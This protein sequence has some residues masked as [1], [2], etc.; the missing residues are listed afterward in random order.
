MAN[1]YTRIKDIITDNGLFPN[2]ALYSLLMGAVL[3]TI[4]LDYAFGSITCG[5][6]LLVVFWAQR[7]VKITVNKALI[8]PMLFYLLML[9]SLFWTK[10]FKAT[11]S[12]LQKEILFL[13]MPV[14]FLLLQDVG[15]NVM[16]GSFRIYSYCMLA[17][18]H[19]YV[20]KAAIQY[21]AS[22]DKTVFFYHGLVSLDSNAIYV[23]VFASFALWYFVYYNNKSI[24][25]R[26]AVFFLAVFI[27]LLSSKSI[28]F[29]NL[30][31]TAIYFIGFSGIPRKVKFL[32]IG[33]ISL[34]MVFSFVFVSQIR[35][36]FLIEYETA[37]TDDTINKEN[38]TITNV[39]LYQAWNTEQFHPNNYFPGTALRIYQIR[40]FKEM[41]S[42]DPILFT[43][44]G[45]EASQHK[46][47]QKRAEHNLHEGYGDFNFHN[48]YVQTFA[49]LGIFGLLLLISMLGFTFRNAWLHKDFL[50]L[51]FA[52]TMVGLL[53]TESFFCRQRGIVFF[54]TLYCMFNTLNPTPKK[55]Q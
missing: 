44:Y 1:I 28:I 52:L 16:T 23:A 20:I 31:L 6:F 50:H 53:L 12:G 8:I 15:K 32:I 25:E 29:I 33:S 26:F 39:S 3:A 14:A 47:K 36:R 4:P 9:L 35:E 22:G 13:L 2:P 17:Y 5:V 7:K 10:D 55:N 11:V 27:F 51:A 54:I 41:L 37:F 43:G 45:L 38:N 34:L 48:Q 46:I 42:E 49:E 30:L 19:Y 21:L 18:G 40:I 24:L